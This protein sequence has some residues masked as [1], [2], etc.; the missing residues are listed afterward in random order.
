MEDRGTAMEADWGTG[1]H[2]ETEKVLLCR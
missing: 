1:N 2:S